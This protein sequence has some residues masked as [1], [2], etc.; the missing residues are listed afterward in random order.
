VGVLSLFQ[1]LFRG[2]LL[3]SLMAS[4]TGCFYWW[5]TYQT[6]R[7]LSDFDEN[8][9]T[10]N[11]ESFVLNFKNP[12]LYSED[13]VSLAKLRP[14]S[15]EKTEQGLLW[16]YEFYKVDDKG[17]QVSPE[18]SFSVSL[19]FNQ[20]DRI[21]SCTFSPLFL[22]I[23]PAEFLEI[24]IRSVAQGKINKQTRQLKVD[25]SKVD[26]ISSVLPLKQ[27]AVAKLGEPIEI[28][29]KDLLQIYIYHFL[30]NAHDI[31]EGYEGRALNV[32]KLFF[33][34]ESQEMVKMSGSFAGLK[35]SIDY[36][37]YQQ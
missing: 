16:R 31:E 17:V 30:L 21:V 10:I 28:I 3:L 23:I 14:T 4:L 36:Q 2:I 32:I 20:D 18:I 25:T 35:I 22:Q 15:E 9:S 33:N 5:R 7:Q 29:E 19:E 24:A 6:Y 27:V 12:R 1:R 11:T 26:K 34:K 8:F 13:F 37:K